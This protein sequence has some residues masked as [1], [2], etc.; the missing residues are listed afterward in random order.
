[1][2]STSQTVY[3]I[4]NIEIARS[5][6]CEAMKLKNYL[7]VKNNDFTIISQNIR[8]IYRNFDDFLLTLSSLS[9]DVD[10]IVLTECHYYN[11]ENVKLGNIL[12]QTCQ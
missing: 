11:T 7:Q 9:F 12:V 4:D 3:E 5:F 8:S 10:V 1:M 6:Q 2:D